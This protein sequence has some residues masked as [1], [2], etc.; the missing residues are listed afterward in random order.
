VDRIT[1]GLR[2][3]PGDGRLDDAVAKGTCSTPSPRGAS[4][5]AWTKTRAAEDRETLPDGIPLAGKSGSMRACATTAGSS[6]PGR[7]FVLVVLTDGSRAE[8]ASSADHPSV[9]AIADVPRRSWTSGAGPPGCDGE[10]QVTAARKVL[11]PVI[12]SEARD[13]LSLVPQAG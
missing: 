12:P 4:S 6:V 9:L 3:G 13:L 5:S 8:S 7:R 1:H 2:D 10:T 11:L